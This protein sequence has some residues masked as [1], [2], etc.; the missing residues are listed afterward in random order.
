VLTYHNTGAF[1]N[2]TNNAFGAK[3]GGFGTPA[4]TT[5]GSLFGGG[6][7]TAGTSGFGGG[8]GASTTPAA[9]SSPFGGTNSGGG[10]FGSTKPTFGGSTTTSNP[11]GGGATNSPFGGTTT[12]AFGSPASTA[13]GGAVGETPG[14]GNV[15]FQPFIEKEPNSTSNQ[16]NSF[17]NI[18]FQP[19]YQKFSPEELRLVDYNQG[20]RYGNASGQAGAFGASNFGGFGSTTTTNT[21]G[22]GA[23]NTN[24]GSS[25]FGGT[26]SSPFGGTSQPATTGFGA[27]AS[28]SGG[29][30]GAKPATGGLFGAQPSQ[31][32]GGLFGTNTNTGFGTPNAG[33]FGTTNTSTG[34][35]L[36]GASST[37]NK[38]FSFGTPQPAASTG[39]GFG[40]APASTGFGGGGLFGNTNQQQNTATGFGN[41]QPAT[42]AFGGFNTNTQQQTS[43]PSLFGS[44]QQKPAGSL[45]GAAPATGT[46]LFGSTQSANNTNPFGGSTNTQNTGGLF[47]SKPASTGTGLFGATNPQNNTGG[48]GLFGGF[49]ANQNQTQPQTSSLFGSLN[50]NNNN[51]NNSA[52]KP[53]LFGN[54]GNQ[55]QGG[56]FG[57]TGNQQQGGG[58][59][60]G[61]NNNN[62]QQTQQ[63]QNSLFG[64]GNSLFGSSQQGQNST[65]QSLTASI[66]DNGAFGSSSLFANLQ[67]TQV[68]NPGPVATPLS[69][70]VQSKKSAAL[71][72]YK[73]NSASASRFTTPSRQRAGFGFSY[74][75]YGSPASAS[76]TASTPGTFGGSMLGGGGTFGRTLNKSMSTSSLRRSFNT[77]DSILAPGAF[78]A[79]PGAKF[80]STGSVKKLTI[81]RSIRQDLFSPPNPQPNSQPPPSS[82]VGGILKKRVSFDQST[83]N[84]NGNSSSS[85]LKQVV[86]GATPSAEDLG[87]LRPRAN[88]NGA[89]PDGV[90]KQPEMEQVTNNNKQLAIVNEEESTAPVQPSPPSAPVSQED[91]LPGE[92]WMQPSREEIDSM[93]RNQRQRVTDFTVG[94]HGIGSIHFDVPADLTSVNLDE[95]VGD[96]VRLEIRSATVYPNAAKKPPMGRGL[97]LP[98]TIT[99]AN[100]W[101][102]KKDGKTSAGDKSGIR[103]RKHVECLKKVGGT[104]FLDYDKD[105]GVW[106]FSV[107]HF[108]T[109]GFPDED[110]ET[111]GDAMSE[112]GQSTLSAPPDTPT[113]KIRIP[114]PQS[115]N[116]SFA[117]SSQLTVTESDPDDTFEFRKKKALPGAFDDEEVYMDENM[118]ENDDEEDRESFLDERS[119]GSLSENR[120]EEPMDHDDVFHDNESV[121]IIDQEIAGSYPEADNTAELVEQ[122]S[123]DD[124]EMDI[125]M[126]T[127][128]AIMRARMRALKNSETPSKQK[129]TVGDDW[130]NTL[131]KTVSPQKQDRKLLKSLIDIHGNEPRPDTEQTPVTRRVISDGRGFATSIDL[132]N[133]LFGQ[134]RSPTKVAKVLAV[135]KGF[136][137][138]VPSPI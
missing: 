59:F 53:S 31:P 64:G 85:P 73:L 6:T 9:A 55:Q 56:L 10:L 100:S 138:G 124:E 91:N 19:P 105:T 16:Q 76:S 8:F 21:G 46:S 111:D 134:A 86:N 33:G 120:V 89:K 28:T 1:G 74:S 45:F 60:G 83:T 62:Q 51:N 88:V 112:F 18:C 114:R 32:S 4:A 11:F 66:G 15:P 23:T 133:S 117:S 14:T 82:P 49:G 137:V 44:N 95:V 84:G 80:A 122:D 58:L 107:L 92:Y 126:E 57:N 125:M 63:P 118:Q 43:A 25:L 29:L 54:T 136:E 34:S 48:G 12:S 41:P 115:V 129:L 94:R 61:L 42:T 104:K 38:P 3:T 81:S 39:T 75:N 2:T 40:G 72:L 50:N 27:T 26:S 116:Q 108:T 101:P 99:L 113:P 121:S 109:Y 87:L 5:G 135:S 96:I 131:A 79:S 127:P 123:Q 130:A 98:A 7:A 13:L 35:S 30:F 119:V 103:F 22:F 20:R 97:N 71:P 106:T 102:R 78:S 132:M 68:N 47:G 70:S 77:E 128:G 36:F 69:S 65:P 52:Q 93:N 24:T 17:Q 37:A 90:A 67:S 110:E